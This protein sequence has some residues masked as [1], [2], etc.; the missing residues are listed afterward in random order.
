M[1]ATLAAIATLAWS[2]ASFGQNKQE[3][4]E[5]YKQLLDR[6]ESLTLLPV[7][8]WKYHADIAHPE[9]PSL[10]DADWATL[11]PR[12]AWKDG[13]RVLRRWIEIPEKINGYSTQGAKV[14]LEL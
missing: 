5:P 6:L 13:S 8:D 4:P 14:T 9:D 1:R 2:C 7:P 11:K 10:S 3:T 12:E